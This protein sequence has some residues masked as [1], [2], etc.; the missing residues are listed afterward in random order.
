[1]DNEAIMTQRPRA[2]PRLFRRTLMI[3]VAIFLLTLTLPEGFPAQTVADYQARRAQAFAL[4]DANKLVD[5]LPLLEKLHAEKPGDVAVLE[6]LGFATVAHSATRTDP[7]VRKQERA[8]ARKLAEEAKVSGDT[9]NLLKVLLEIPED[10]GDMAFPG[11]AAVQDALQQGE[12]AFARGDFDGAIAAYGQALALDPKQYDA[13]V[14]TGDVYFRKGDH[15]QADEWFERAVA[16][17]PNR[18][19]AYRY[20]GDNLLAEGRISD[21]KDQFIGAVV[22][23]PYN[24]R[25]W[26]GL[27]QWA[28]RQSLWL[29]S[30]RIASPNQIQDTGKNQTNSIVDAATLEPGVRK[31]GT[32]AWFSYT[33]VRAGWHGEKFHKEF[34]AEKDYRHSLPEEV[35]GLQAVVERVRAGLNKNE[36]R[37]LDP[38]LAS[39]VKLSDEGLLESY[40][41]ISRADQGIS[42]DYPAYRDAYREKIR[43][44]LSEWIIHSAN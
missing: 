28:K 9:S 25:S 27:S 20:W 24:Q 19:T 21:A 26:M 16:I 5:A 1:M 35:D 44:Y 12:A 30:P 39:L 32:D 42:Q 6:R 4:Y 2:L 31:D 37:R 17:N 11:S 10:G 18:E 38:G 29:G 34:P 41:L 36:I 15:Q 3:G 13:A 7:V 43:R 40:V 8:R 22:A 14:F 33:L 23:E